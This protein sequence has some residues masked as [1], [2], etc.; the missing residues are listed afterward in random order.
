M[1]DIKY[2]DIKCV[3]L[4]SSN[5]YKDIYNLSIVCEID[6]RWMPKYGVILDL[7]H[8]TSHQELQSKNHF[9][10]DYENKR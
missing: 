3:R 10:V 9:I 6:L 2:C 5:L 4:R 8:I 7:N 1:A